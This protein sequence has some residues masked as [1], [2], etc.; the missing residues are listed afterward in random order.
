M[1]YF[2]M[3]GPSYIC[4]LNLNSVTLCQAACGLPFNWA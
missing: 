1:N 4:L 3:F 2:K